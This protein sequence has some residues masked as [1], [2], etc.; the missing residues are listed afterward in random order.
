MN[1]NITIW[2]IAALALCLALVG[3]PATDEASD[4]NALAGVP[5]MEAIARLHDFPE[6]STTMRSVGSKTEAATLF[7]S[8]TTALTT[9]LLAQ[10]NTAY[11]SESG[12]FPRVVDIE[13]GSGQQNYTITRTFDEHKLTGLTGLNDPDA[14]KPGIMNGSNTATAIVKSPMTL[15]KYFGTNFNLPD[16]S[17]VTKT[18]LV[19]KDDFIT[20]RFSGK[21]DFAITDGFYLA[22]NTNVAG[23][24]TIDYSGSTTKTLFDKENKIFTESNSDDITFSVTIV[25]YTTTL[26][27]KFRL[28]GTTKTSNATTRAVNTG[29]GLTISNLEVFTN[30]GSKIY[31]LPPDQS[32]EQSIGIDYQSWFKFA[33]DVVARS[34]SVKF[35][36]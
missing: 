13:N 27:A 22:S 5:G 15:A 11:Y 2:G 4:D 7:N 32:F 18:G 6:T 33:K 36:P 35:N 16:V 1:R 24:V 9:T 12:G 8:A 21:R 25:A 3:C 20:E 28:S 14:E 34:V 30:N 31:T 26:G 17:P 23:Y 19:D 10:D 29:N